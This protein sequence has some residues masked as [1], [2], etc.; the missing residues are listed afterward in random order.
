MP[1]R[2]LLCSGEIYSRLKQSAFSLLSRLHH[3]HANKVLNVRQKQK[4]RL[5][6]LHAVVWAWTGLHAEVMTT[7]SAGISLA[8]TQGQTR[9]VHPFI[10]ISKSNQ[11]SYNKLP[12]MRRPLRMFLFGMQIT[13]FSLAL[14]HW[15]ANNLLLKVTVVFL[16]SVWVFG[17]A[18][19]WL[20]GISADFLLSL[21]QPFFLS[22][23]P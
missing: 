16:S 23:Y 4:N 15:S 17:A 1:A 18:Q 2:D 7:Q 19:L 11:T 12:H 14:S 6:L 13:D 3:G 5:V 10:K 22:Q 8:R 21:V 20:G 9:G